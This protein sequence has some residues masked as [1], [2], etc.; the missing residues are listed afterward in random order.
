VAVC[1]AAGVSLNTER[2][3]PMPTRGIHHPKRRGTSSH[4]RYRLAILSEGNPS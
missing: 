1:M 2:I 4:F 3:L